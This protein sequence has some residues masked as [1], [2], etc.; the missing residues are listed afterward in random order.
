MISEL[1]KIEFNG[2]VKEIVH[3]YQLKYTNGVSQGLGDYIRGSLYLANLANKLKIKFSMNLLKHPISQ[4][5]IPHNTSDIE[6][7]SI[8]YQSIERETC[9]SVLGLMVDPCKKYQGEEFDKMMQQAEYHTINLINCCKSAQYLTFTNNYPLGSEEEL[10][11]NIILTI[12][13]H[14]TPTLELASHLDNMLA[15]LNFEKYKYKTIHIRLDDLYFNN[16]NIRDT[17]YNQII[18][19]LNTIDNIL[20]DDKLLLISNNLLI[21]KI[22]KQLYPNINMLLY[23]DV[24]HFGGDSNHITPL[25]NTNIINTLTDFFLLSFSNYNYIITEAKHGSGFS[26]WCSVIHSTPYKTMII[27]CEKN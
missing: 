5:L 2:N 21:K 12:K 9:F 27:D 16:N 24:S 4:Y 8:E 23:D 6:Y 10:D 20:S 18:D 15:K 22:I 13:S 3:V 11:K 14:L 26:I 17:S 7:Q 19:Y 1:E 25:T